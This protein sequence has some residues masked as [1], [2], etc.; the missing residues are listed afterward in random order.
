MRIGDV[1]PDSQFFIP[2]SGNWEWSY[3]TYEDFAKEFGL[4]TPMVYYLNRG[5]N[6]KGNIYYII[7]CYNIFIPINGLFYNRWEK[8]RFQL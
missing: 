3:Y 5:F 4:N 7:I 8:N 2:D 6:E 1:T